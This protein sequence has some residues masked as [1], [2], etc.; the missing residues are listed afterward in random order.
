[1]ILY[2]LSVYTSG[3]VV[4]LVLDCLPNSLQAWYLFVGPYLWA[5]WCIAILTTLQIDQNDL[6]H[7]NF[8]SGFL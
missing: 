4:Q 5:H 6:Q 3:Q 1:M 2:G 7:I 8:N